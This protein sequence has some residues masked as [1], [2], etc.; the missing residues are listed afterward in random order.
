MPSRDGFRKRG[1][2]RTCMVSCGVFMDIED[3]RV[4]RMIGD[5]DDP[6][7]HGYTCAKGRDVATHLYGPNRILRPLRGNRP[8]EFE[9][10]SSGQAISEI[11]EK[12]GSIVEKHGPHAVA[13][14]GGTYALAPPGGMFAGS[15]MNAL[16]SP[17]N[18][19]CGSIDQPG[20]L[21]AQALHGRWHAGGQPFATAETWLFIGTNPA[22]S[23]LGGAPTTNPNWHLTQAVK[24]G[25]QMIVIDPRRT[26]T[27][28]K[29]AIHLQPVPGQ[30][31]AV[32]CPGTG[33]R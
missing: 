13:F 6:A 10:I 27:A 2:C 32:S 28:R 19:S 4:T 29:A 17:M 26:E 24:R 30:D 14:Y 8:G 12:L 31:T 18:F 3:G 1:I 9:E 11:A 15:F 7:S 21:L 33:W 5:K 16:G 23:G 25:I 22:I 20:K